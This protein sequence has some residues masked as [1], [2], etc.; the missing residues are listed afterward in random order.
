MKAYFELQC[1]M[2]NRRFKDTGFAPWFAYIILTLGFV[3]LSIYLFAKTEFAQYAYMLAALTLI[4][5][6]SETRRTE[7]LK[8]C[9]GDTKLKKIR[10][11][12]N[13]ICALPFLIFL[14]Y[15]QLIFTALLLA[16]LTTILALV[17][18][19]T[20]LNFTLWTPFSKRP[21]EFAIGF[22]NTFYLIFIAYALTIIAVSVHNFNLGV[23]SLLLVLASTLSYYNKPENEYY[24]WIHNLNAK[25]FLFSKI[26]T[27]MLFSASLALPIAITLAIFYPQNIGIL[28]LFFGV[29]WLLLIGVIVGKYAAY[30]DEMNIVQGILLALS[31]WFPPV[32]VVL[33][34]YFFKK[35]ENRLSRL[36]K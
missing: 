7:F 9:F 34:P 24:V 18:F 14:L 5:K 12:E 30:P 3:A 21:F 32:L 23:F 13:F 8:I 25:K 27:A 16:V 11:A 2:T 36:L 31:I 6:L 29:G 35:S 1:K 19:S 17:N 22:R 4:G 33:I 28:T 20:T 26:K 10:V 15:Q